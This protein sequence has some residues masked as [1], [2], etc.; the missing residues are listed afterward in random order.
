M[1]VI[2][3]QLIEGLVIGTKGE[4]LIDSNKINPHCLDIQ[5][6][7]VQTSE[8]TSTSESKNEE[9]KI[10]VSDFKKILL[11]DTKFFSK[12]KFLII[13]YLVERKVTKIIKASQD[14]VFEEFEVLYQVN[15]INL[16]QKNE[17]PYIWEVNIYNLFQR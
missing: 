1:K 13:I 17:P 3:E 12:V 15:G 16:S 14:S 7:F 10:Q 5:N 2:G 9:V 11:K 8:G 6:E 4:V